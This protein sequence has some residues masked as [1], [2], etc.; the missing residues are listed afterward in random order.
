MENS[1]LRD[2]FKQLPLV[3]FLSVVVVG[4]VASGMAETEVDGFESANF[5]STEDVVRVAIK[6]DFA[7]ASVEAKTDDVTGMRRWFVYVKS[8][9][10]F[11]VPAQIVYGF[12]YK[13]KTL[14]QID[15]A[16][17]LMGA[18]RRDPGAVRQ[19]IGKLIDLYAS[20]DW[21]N[22]SVITG[23]FL[24]N[25]N[26]GNPL[27]FL[28]FRGISRQ[29]RMIALLGWPVYAKS[30]KEGGGVEADFAKLQKLSVIYQLDARTP[31]VRR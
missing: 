6:K 10:P 11:N 21:V 5:G 20:F 16:W 22:G 25:V 2:A 4:A 28:F 31:D 3:V 23:Y 29:N 30:G 15:I 8:L 13:T 27:R 24:G 12:G 19:A 26:V 9:P 18:N 14:T 7:D 1:K 17:D